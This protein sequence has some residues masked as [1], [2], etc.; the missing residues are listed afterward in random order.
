MWKFVHLIN[1][2]G[3]LSTYVFIKTLFHTHT[4]LS[5][6]LSRFFVTRAFFYASVDKLNFSFPNLSHE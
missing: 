4:R 2:S 3:P 5:N 6:E 1:H